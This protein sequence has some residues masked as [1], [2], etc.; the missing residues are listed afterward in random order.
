MK[1]LK[2]EDN[3]GVYI[4]IMFFNNCSYEI[5]FFGLVNVKVRIVISVID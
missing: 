5:F 3:V 2:V 4:I 1:I